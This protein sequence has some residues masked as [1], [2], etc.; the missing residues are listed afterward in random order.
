MFQGIWL[1]IMG[2]MLW[3]PGL[4][5][6]GC[7]MNLEEGHLVVRCRSDEALHRAK[8]LVNIEFSW[9]LVCVTVFSV[10]VYLV[11]ARIYGK[12]SFEYE[13]IRS[14]SDDIELQ[15]SNTTTKP[16]LQDDGPSSKR[17]IHDVGKISGYSAGSDMER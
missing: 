6:K 1:M 11:L 7:F 4:I 9:F 12:D 5:P 16:A 8:S 17:F 10:S 13:A 2:F 14:E 3:T 15:K